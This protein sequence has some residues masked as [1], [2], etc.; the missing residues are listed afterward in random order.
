MIGFCPLASGSKGNC[1]YL[2]TKNTKILI[3]AGISF[4]QIE[5]RLNEINV[6]IEEIDAILI[7]HEHM[8]HIYGIKTLSKKVNIPIIVNADTAKGIYQNIYFLPECK[9]F[10]SNETFEFKDLKIHPFSIQHDTLDPV[11]FVFYI[12][13]MKIGFC[14]DLGYVTSIVSEQLKGCDYLY[15]ESN[16]QESMVHASLRPRTYK[17]RVLGRQGHLSNDS[18]IELLKL[19]YNDNLKHVYL[20]HLSSECNSKELAYDKVKNFFENLKNLNV[21]ISIAHQEK[22]SN[23]IYFD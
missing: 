13:N 21:K 20:A 5:K 18:L 4:K 6:S 7:T 12:Q 9:I 23:P 15:L 19:I 10:T 8:D 2:G 16:H 14:T 17:E 22:V 11:G 3:D 1:V